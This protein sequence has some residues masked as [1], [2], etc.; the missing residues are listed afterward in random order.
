MS[1]KKTWTSADLA[2]NI[3]TDASE[4]HKCLMDVLRN[5]ES[6]MARIKAAEMLLSRAYGKVGVVPMHVQDDGKEFEMLSTQEKLARV[7]AAREALLKQAEQ[8]AAGG[9][10]ILQ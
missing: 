9:E 7:N 5:S 4:I 8:E 3:K 6:D 1:S 10:A 2:E